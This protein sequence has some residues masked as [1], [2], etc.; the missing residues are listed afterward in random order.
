MPLCIPLAHHKRCEKENSTRRS[1]RVEWQGG[2]VGP[3]NP[4]AL[5]RANESADNQPGSALHPICESIDGFARLR[6]R[7]DGSASGPPRPWT[8]PCVSSLTELATHDARAA[9][10]FGSNR[11]ARP[12]SVMFSAIAS[13]GM[14]RYLHGF[15]GLRRRMVARAL[16][17]NNRHIALAESYRIPHLAF[18][19]GL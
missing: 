15:A 2:A 1:R 5:T 13:C 8:R 9:A 11:A 19:F 3:C 6:S 18:P 7:F 16:A 12:F 10:H 17:P 14:R 4:A